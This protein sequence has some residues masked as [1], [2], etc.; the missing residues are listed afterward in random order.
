MNGIGGEIDDLAK[1]MYM[2]AIVLCTYYS[3]IKINNLDNP[4]FIKKIILLVTA[5]SISILSM[6][7][8]YNLQI[9]L[10]WIVIIFIISIVNFFLYKKDSTDTMILTAIAHSVSYVL[11]VVAL[12][13]AFFPNNI[14]CINNEFVEIVIILIIYYLITI[15]IFKIKRIKYGIIFLKKKIENHYLKVLALDIFAIV[16]LSIVTLQSYSGLGVDKFGTAFIIISVIVFHTIKQFIDMYYKQ[17]LLTKDL[18][19]IQKELEAKSI[20]VEKLEKENLEFSK[21]SHSLAHKQK[22]LEFKL[23]Q[24]MKQQPNAESK[25]NIKEEIDNLNKEVYKEPNDIGISKT[26]IESIDNMLLYMQSECIKD[27]IKFELQV[28]GNIYYMINN[29]IVENDLEILLADHIKDAI[30]AINFSDNSNRSILVR[31]GNIDNVYSVYFY[32]S[33]LE[34]EKEVLDNLG[35]KPI[36]TH[37]DSGGTGMGFMNTFETLNKTKASLLINEI[38]KPCIDNYTK[39]LVIKFDNK[40]EFKVHSYKDK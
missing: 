26:G 30:F 14:L 23:E 19:Q 15:C 10:S 4:N 34:F 37:A 1:I 33:G 38:G 3:Y 32:D 35:R 27:N 7:M 5:F 8:K 39:V 18:E 36:T 6:I 13:V 11:F 21:T 20:E 31:I 12:M 16:L 2:C 9:Y 25:K 22:A 24:F 17:K 29:L 40:N 28:V